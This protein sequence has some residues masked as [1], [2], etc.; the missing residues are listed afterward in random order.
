[1]EDQILG[2]PVQEVTHTRF[3]VNLSCF[4]FVKMWT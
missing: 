3:T 1:M 2:S 4:D